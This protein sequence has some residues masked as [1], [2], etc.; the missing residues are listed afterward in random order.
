MIKTVLFDL[1]GTL[2]NTLEDLKNSTNFALKKFEFPQ[3][4][5]E[6]IRRAVGNGLRRLI[7]LSV[8]TGTADETIDAVLTEMKAHYRLHCN[9]AT[10]PYDGILPLLRELKRH[11]IQTAVVSNKAAPM[12]EL[13]C[14]AHF[15]GLIDAAFG[16]SPAMRRKPAPDMIDAALSALGSTRSEA[17]Y[18][19]DS[20]VDVLTAKNAALPCL[21]VGWGF[22]TSA[23]LSAGHIGTVYPT[24]SALAEALLFDL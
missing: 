6:E 3:K 14:R 18:V 16:E 11:G 12:T 5:A 17:V 8:P 1:D 4:T 24:V 23:E 2:L 21:I 9:D 19:G 10:A 20:E 13:L 15:D 22:R 7:A